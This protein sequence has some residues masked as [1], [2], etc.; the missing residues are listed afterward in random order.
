MT[1]SLLG[2]ATREICKSCPSNLQEASVNVPITFL[3]STLL[4]TGLV[5]EQRQ[6][7]ELPKAQAAMIVA[8]LSCSSAPTLSCAGSVSASP[9]CLSDQYFIDIYTFNA[10]SGQAI[11]ITTTTTT[12][13]QMLVT[14]QA[15]SGAILASNHGSSPLSLSY[16]FPAS[17]AYFIGFGYIATFA[18]GTY[19][20]SVA[21]GSTTGTCH[22]S[23]TLTLGTA[24]AGQ[25]TA[26]NGTACLGGNT[27]SAV[28]GFN[29][30]KDVPVLITFSSS[31]PPYVQAEPPGGATG[32]WKSSD[33]G[34]AIEMTFLPATTGNHWVYFTSNTATPVPG[35][36]A[37]KVVNAPVDPCRRRGVSH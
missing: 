28:Y 36:Y 25:L 32:V 1:F 2:D 20:L 24:V 4:A 21:C 9:S 19:T 33:T 27:Y 12:S 31:F 35:S 6:A 17:G 16:T 29:G 14:V 7:A 8:P 11:T 13:Y 37:V 26:A 18:T 5:A 23:G 34:G 30:V 10:S 22:S 15:A 3:L